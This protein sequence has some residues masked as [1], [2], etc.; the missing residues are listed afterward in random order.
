MWQEE[1]YQRIRAL[2]ATL[3]RVTTDRIVTE[4]NVSRETVRRDL[5]ALEAL[6]ELKRIHGGAIMV[7]DEAPIAER[8]HINVKF[9]RDLAR[10][11]VGLLS[12]G[13]TIFIDAGT[14]TEILAQ[15]LAKLGGLT[16]ITNAFNVAL[17]L[18]GSAP[19]SLH[20]EVIILG[21]S[22]GDRSPATVGATTVA[23]IGRYRADLALLSPVG[24]DAHHGASNYDHRES[25]VARAMAEHAERVVILADYSKLG[26]QSRISFCPPERIDVLVTNQRASEE[27]AFEALKARF[28]EIILA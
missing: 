14:T 9:K 1:R 8:A 17:H 20:N 26:V 18:R 19:G 3:Q 13:Q 21:G 27:V 24:V 15:E 5:V 28:K 2:L 12:H 7:E 16:V 22:L 23:E 6:G 25:E 4:L 11:A 10:A